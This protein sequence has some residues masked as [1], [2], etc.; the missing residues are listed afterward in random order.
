[1][2]GGYPHLEHNLVEETRNQMRNYGDKPDPRNGIIR[3]PQIKR[4]LWEKYDKEIRAAIDRLKK[5]NYKDIPT[6]KKKN[7]LREIKLT[8]ARLWLRYRCQIINRIKGNKSS[9]YRNNMACRLCKSGKNGTQEHLERCNFS[10]DMKN[11]D[12]NMREDKIVLLRNITRALKDIYVVNTN[13]PNQILS[14]TDLIA[15]TLDRE[16]TPN[17]EGQREALPASDRKPAQGVVMV[18]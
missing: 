11:L 13:I 8:N 6:K 7:Y 17:P 4:G 18:S 14:T 1:M 5:V 12:L 3:Q 16:K 15:D 2:A 10:K 9:M